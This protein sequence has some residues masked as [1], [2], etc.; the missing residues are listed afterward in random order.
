MSSIG[1]IPPGV[2]QVLSNVKQ[3]SNGYTH[4]FG[5]ALLNGHIMISYIA[6]FSKKFKMAAVTPD[7]LLKLTK[8]EPKSTFQVVA[9]MELQ[10]AD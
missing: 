8:V 5:G 6:P 1:E 10:P 4:V 7:L 3:N 9:I 2:S